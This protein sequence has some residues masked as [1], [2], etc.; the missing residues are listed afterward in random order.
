MNACVFAYLRIN[1]F[2]TKRNSNHN[3]IFCVE[4]TWI[5]YDVIYYSQFVLYNYEGST[6]IFLEIQ[7]MLIFIYLQRVK[8]TSPDINMIQYFNGTTKIFLI[9]I[10]N[11]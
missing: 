1:F 7:K 4:S 6:I 8:N 11:A 2:K 10:K 5:G 9:W 3:N